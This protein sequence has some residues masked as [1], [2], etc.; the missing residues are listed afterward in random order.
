MDSVSFKGKF[1]LVRVLFHL[2]RPIC[3]IQSWESHMCEFLWCFIERRDLWAEPQ[4]LA[5][6]KKAGAGFLGGSVKDPP[7]KQEMQYPSLGQEDPLEEE[8]ATQTSISAWRIPWTEEPGK[9]QYMGLQKSQTRLSDRAAAATT[10][11]AGAPG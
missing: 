1:Y 8:M 5:A 9:L 7:A 3:L 11:E 2:L 4:N 6:D 10:K